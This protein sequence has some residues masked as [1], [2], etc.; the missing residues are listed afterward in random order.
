ME[1]KYICLDV[2]VRRESP[3]FL[4]L[5]LNDEPSMKKSQKP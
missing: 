5:L 1:L 2:L 4:I 3:I